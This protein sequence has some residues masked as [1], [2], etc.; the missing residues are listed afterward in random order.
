M[1]LIYQ[2][3]YRKNKDLLVEDT[4]DYAPDLVKHLFGG[5]YYFQ[6]LQYAATESGRNTERRYWQQVN[7]DQSNMN[8]WNLRAYGTA[9]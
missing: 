8:F 2:R 7:A 9:F 1:P 6:E 4:K 3:D 5:D